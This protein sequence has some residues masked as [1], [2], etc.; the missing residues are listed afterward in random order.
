MYR[1]S[2]ASQH[3]RR[4]HGYCSLEASIVR[5]SAVKTNRGR[6]VNLTL[7]YVLELKRVLEK[8]CRPYYDD[9]MPPF[10]DMSDVR[11]GVAV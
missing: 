10:L 7:R 8:S 2:S 1:L 4:T 6:R 5:R 3:R 11:D 9:E